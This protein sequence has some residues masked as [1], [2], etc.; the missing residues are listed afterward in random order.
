LWSAQTCLESFKKLAK[1]AFRRHAGADLPL[2][3]WIVAYWMDSF[4]R[5]PDLEAQLQ[6]AFQPKTEERLLFGDD[7]SGPFA[8]SKQRS[9]ALKVAVSATTTINPEAY[10]I[11]NYNRKKNTDGMYINLC[12]VIS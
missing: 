8:A 6:K 10:L 7:F 5:T 9:R 1:N 4:Y 12:I 11:T 2:I 3:G